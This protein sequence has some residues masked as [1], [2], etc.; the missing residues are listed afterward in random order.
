MGV[1]PAEV[2]EILWISGLLKNSNRNSETIVVQRFDFTGII[3]KV[4]NDSFVEWI[5]F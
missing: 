4:K 5:S 1:D 3:I 2:N